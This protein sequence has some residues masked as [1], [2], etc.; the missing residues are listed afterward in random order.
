[1]L[2]WL[3][4]EKESGELPNYSR[5]KSISSGGLPPELKE[6]E[7]SEAFK[8]Q[9]E[10]IKCELLEP[11]KRPHD[12]T[13][14]L[15]ELLVVEG[16]VV[17]IPIPNSAGQ[18]L[19]SFST[20]FR[21]A[22]YVR[23]LLTSDAR[24]QYLSSSP[25]QFISMLRDLEGAGVETFTVDR[26]P[27]CSF[28]TTIGSSSMKNAAD[29]VMVWAIHKATELTRSDLYFSYALAAACAGRLE[30]ARDVALESVGHVSLEDPRLHLLLGQLAIGLGD[31]TLLREAR[32][33]LRFLNL[34]PWE[35]KLDEL[36]RSGSQDFTAPK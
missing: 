5:L 21:A 35:R 13:P 7:R 12:D 36:E 32:T 29:V 10:I 4:G 11:A 34:I 22:D 15:T 20:P 19:L 27:R 30:V 8:S 6:K 17:T 1:M 31:R 24:V 33:F 3:R 25:L 26:C 23:T 14:L 9:R 28:V 16:G 2:N 18:C